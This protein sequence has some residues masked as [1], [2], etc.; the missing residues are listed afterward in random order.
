MLI[1]P[2][3]HSLKVVKPVMIILAAKCLPVVLSALS[4]LDFEISL[5]NLISL[6]SADADQAVFCRTVNE[7]IAEGAQLPSAQERCLVG[8]EGNDAIAFLAPSSGT[9]GLPKVLCMPDFAL[10]Q[11]LN[12]V[13]NPGCLYHASKC[14]HHGYPGGDI[15]WS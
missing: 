4:A 12:F 13:F 3:V 9:T 2:V 14:D 10:N 7:L 1:F 8:R 15:Q 5:D 6:D 11:D